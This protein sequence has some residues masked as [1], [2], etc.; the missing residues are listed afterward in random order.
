MEKLDADILL[1]QEPYSINGHIPGFG[2]GARV[3]SR[4]NV[5]QPPWAAICVRNRGFT[6]LEISDLCTTHCVCV[7]I[8]IDGAEIYVV[9]QYFPP[10][11]DIGVGLAHLDRIVTRLKGRILVIGAD[12]N[13]KSHLWHSGRTDGRGEELEQ[14]IARH[15]L[16]VL[17]EPGQPTTFQS[18]R[19]SSNIDVTLASWEAIPLMSTWKVH[20]SGS[21][22]DHR[23]I[24]TRLDLN[25][26]WH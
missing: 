13:A 24:E 18:T 17:N 8:S 26:R 11:V 10:S 9:S 16:L 3:I 19:G 23:I 14:L 21:S 5:G 25:Q 12:A 22:S 6:V 1:M 20:E 15:D 4:G 7:Q 2:N